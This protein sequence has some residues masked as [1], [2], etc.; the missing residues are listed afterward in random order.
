M[1][2]VV[3]V[4]PSLKGYQVT[5]MMQ[6]ALFDFLKHRFEGRLAA[7]LHFLLCSTLCPSKKLQITFHYSRIIITRVPADISLGKRSVLNNPTKRAITERSTHRENLAQVQA[8]IERIFELARTL[9]V[10]INLYQS[11]LQTPSHTT[12]TTSNSNILQAIEIILYEC[13]SW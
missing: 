8:E 13:S 4:G 3:L 9:Q 6:K 11:L 1:R 7:L 10:P 2:P 12:M 5:D